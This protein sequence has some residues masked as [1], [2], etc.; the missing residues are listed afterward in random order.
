MILQDSAAFFDQSVAHIPGE[1]ADVRLLFGQAED[2]LHPAVCVFLRQDPAFPDP[3]KSLVSA[4]PFVSQ[5]T[6]GEGAERYQSTFVDTD[7]GVAFGIVLADI[8]VLVSRFTA[9]DIACIPQDSRAAAVGTADGFF[10]HFCYHLYK[11][12]WHA[13]ACTCSDF[14][15]SDFK[16]I[17][18]VFS[19][20]FAQ[21]RTKM[22]IVSSYTTE[23]NGHLSCSAQCFLSHA[24]YIVRNRL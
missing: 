1:T 10:L 15:L 11:Q 16:G 24:R 2:I 17:L 21:I 20:F 3:V 4:D 8:Q 18:E 5:F 7:I 14:I 13:L 19:I 23:V 22:E 9:V 6:V 12:K